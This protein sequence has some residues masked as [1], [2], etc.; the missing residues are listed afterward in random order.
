MWSID[1]SRCAKGV[2]A[3]QAVKTGSNP[4]GD[5]KFKGPCSSWLQGPFCR[6]G[7]SQMSAPVHETERR[8][9]CMYHY[10]I[11]HIN[12]GHVDAS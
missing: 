11:L 4:V 10:K 7:F 9:F 3:S 5:A 8:L 1:L 12:C 2:P 6:F